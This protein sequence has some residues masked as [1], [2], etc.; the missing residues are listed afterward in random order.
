M[1]SAREKL[2]ITPKLIDLGDEVIAVGHIARASCVS[3]HP[4]RLAGAGGVLLAVAAIGYEFALGKGLGAINA[5]G[6]TPIWLAL[7]AAGIGIF[8]TVYQR[9]AL[10]IATSDGRTLVIPGARDAFLR[11]VVARIGEA[12][13]ARPGEHLHYVVDLKAGTVRPVLGGA[14]PPAEI[15]DLHGPAAV[16]QSQVAA[17]IG[18]PVAQREPAA[19]EAPAGGWNGAAPMNGQASQHLPHARDAIVVPNRPQQAHWA[20]AQWTA[21]ADEGDPF[22][23]GPQPNGAVPSGPHGAAAVATAAVSPLPRREFD[24]LIALVMRSN[25]QHKAALLDLLNVVDDH[26][27][28]GQTGPEDARAHWQSFSGYVEQ[29]L[30]DVEGLVPMTR[31]VGRSLPLH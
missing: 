2:E 14:N 29:Y 7:V 8:A 30:V 1:T 22:A 3:G 6:S 18:V 20:S 4:F 31:R 19:G 10:T 25:I 5:G 11:E 26:M 12:I 17:S 27:K 15:R 28:G 9:R 21:A 23:N 13:S 24:A 16:P